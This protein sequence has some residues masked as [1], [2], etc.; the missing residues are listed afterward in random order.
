MNLMHSPTHPGAILKEWLC[1]SSMAKFA[2]HLGTSPH[3]LSRILNGQI[4]VSR[5][6]AKRLSKLL[7]T[8]V[9]FW[10]ELQR[11]YDKAVHLKD[12]A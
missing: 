4:S 2:H 8:S 10:L 1:G 3:H 9:G 7:G 12:M 5:R 11:N 6:M